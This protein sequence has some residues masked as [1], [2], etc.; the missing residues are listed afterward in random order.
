MNR[1]PEDRIHKYVW[2]VTCKVCGKT[3]C[4]KG[5][6]K[7]YIPVPVLLRRIP[8]LGP[9]RKCQVKSD[10]QKYKAFFK[11]KGGGVQQGSQDYCI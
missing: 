10:V 2:L 5:K 7:R 11:D 9:C 1:V 6:A 3:F 8:Y 4:E